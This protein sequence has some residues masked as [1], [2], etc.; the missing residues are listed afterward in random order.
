MIS[1]EPSR[2]SPWR[3][4]LDGYLGSPVTVWFVNLLPRSGYAPEYEAWLLKH[5]E[6]LHVQRSRRLDRR[7][8]TLDVW[9]FEPKSRKAAAQATAEHSAD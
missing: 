6:R 7:E 5:A 3:K 9:R 1:T 8:V 4:H 2:A